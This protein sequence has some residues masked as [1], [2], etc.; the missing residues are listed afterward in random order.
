MPEIKGNK[1]EWSEIYLLFKLLADK[2]LQ[3]GDYNLKKIENLFYPIISIMRKENDGDFLYQLINDLVII[4]HNG[5][6]LHL[7]SEEFKKQ[8]VILLS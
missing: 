4:N 3:V 8:A 1:G 6:K 2:K 5:E 7:T